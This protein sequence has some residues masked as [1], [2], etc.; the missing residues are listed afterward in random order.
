LLC[1]S[2]IFSPAPRHHGYLFNGLFR[3]THITEIL[4]SKG[5]PHGCHEFGEGRLWNLSYPP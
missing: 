2:E 5:S 1:F 3:V 4:E